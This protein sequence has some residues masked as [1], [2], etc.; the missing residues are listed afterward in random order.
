M[1]VHNR[2]YQVLLQSSTLLSIERCSE[3]ASVCYLMGAVI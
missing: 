2:V 3:A 1:K